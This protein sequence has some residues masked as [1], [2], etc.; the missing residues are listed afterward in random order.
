MKIL[1]DI[2]LF[3]YF[4]KVCVDLYRCCWFFFKQKKRVVNKKLK[5]KGEKFLGKKRKVSGGEEWHK[6]W[7]LYFYDSCIDNVYI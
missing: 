7:F 4:L 1:F 3:C 6:F 5:K 2:Y